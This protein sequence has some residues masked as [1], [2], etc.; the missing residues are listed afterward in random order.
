MQ[1]VSNGT[2]GVLAAWADFRSGTGDIFAQFVDAQGR[3]GFLAPSIASVR[4]VP[5]DQGGWVRISI[6]RPALD[7]VAGSISWA[8]PG[9]CGMVCPEIP[10]GR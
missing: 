1:V 5:G 6:D 3:T 10:T 4:N 9:D 8:I 2:H 7:M